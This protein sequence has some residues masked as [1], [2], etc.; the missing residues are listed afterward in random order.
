MNHLLL[1]GC[2]YISTANTYLPWKDSRRGTHG[3]RLGRTLVGIS[4]LLTKILMYILHH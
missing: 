3:G 4:K 1:L 2:R